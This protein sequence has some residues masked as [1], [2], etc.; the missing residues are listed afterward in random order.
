MCTCVL[1]ACP[2]AQV[3]TSPELG[4][5][6]PTP[7]PHQHLDITSTFLPLRIHH[8]LNA[9]GS[10]KQTKQN[11]IKESN[12]QPNTYLST[13]CS[14]A[15]QTTYERCNRPVSFLMFNLLWASVREGHS[16]R[17][18]WCWRVWVKETFCFSIPHHISMH[19]WM[20]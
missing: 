16:R 10:I 13:P 9:D 2:R 18:T 7:H 14:L 12:K 8:H 11:A 4:L 1:S 19:V 5:T 15:N 17:S 6:A 3:L 20:C